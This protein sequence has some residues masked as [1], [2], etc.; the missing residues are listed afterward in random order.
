VGLIGACVLAA[1]GLSGCNNAA[2][3]MFTGSL[4]GALGG[5]AI[6][7][8]G[9]H[10]GDGAVVGAVLGGIGGAVIGDQNARWDCGYRGGY[11]DHWCR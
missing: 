4:L 6:G 11:H 5:M 7:S 2:Q 1:A 3:G 10:M 9:G 8:T